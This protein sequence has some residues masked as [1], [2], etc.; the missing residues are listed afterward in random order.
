[1][2][3]PIE[4]NSPPRPESRLLAE[5]RRRKILELLEID[6]R[7]TVD[8]LARRF[9]VSAVTVR[10]DLDGL[11][12]LGALRR[13]HGG[14][15][16]AVAPSDDYPLRLKERLH[17]DEKLRIA[18]AAASLVQPGQTIIL[19]SGST[20][21]EIARQFKQTRIKGITVITN[22]LGIAAELADASGITVIMIGGIVRELSRSCVGPHAEQMMRDLHADH[23]FLAVDGLHVEAGPSTPD[24]LEAQLN[25]LMVR[26]AGAVT[27]VADSSKFGRRSMS[28]I[29]SVEQ[30][31]RVITD[32]AAAPQMVEALRSQHVEVII[33]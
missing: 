21:A 13:S 18:C 12:E 28:I 22:S 20:T 23:L 14:A 25:G 24:I 33:A 16:R 19:D 15:V 27:I 1:M 31:D 29:A 9:G 6:G 26:A 5:E 32:A 17:H 8:E 4:T 10:T 11:S 7:V 30:I 3:P 2:T